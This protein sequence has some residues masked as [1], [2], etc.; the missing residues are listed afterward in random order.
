MA[1]YASII[2]DSPS[3]EPS[4]EEIKTEVLKHTSSCDGPGFL[5]HDIFNHGLVWAD[6]RGALP[7]YGGDKYSFWKIRFV[8]ERQA[9]EI[10]RRGYDFWKGCPKAVFR[11][12]D[13]R[14]CVG[15]F[16]RD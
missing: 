13:G 8:E 12:T 1:S 9:E 4:L 5:G 7:Y 3:L 6:D 15:G 14:I 16:H 10:A 2:F 11:L